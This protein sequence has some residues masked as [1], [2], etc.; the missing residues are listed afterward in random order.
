MEASRCADIHFESVWRQQAFVGMT[1]EQVTEYLSRDTLHMK[2]EL[3]V[4][5]A[6]LA[7]LNYNMDARK[8]QTKRIKSELSVVESGTSWFNRDT[9]ARNEQTKRIVSCFRM[10]YVHPTDL[11]RILQQHPVLSKHISADEVLEAVCTFTAGPCLKKR[12]LEN[13]TDRGTSIIYY[14]DTQGIVIEAIYDATKVKYR[15]LPQLNQSRIYYGLTMWRSFLY[16][17]GGK[18]CRKDQ[19]DEFLQ[20][21]ERFDPYTKKWEVLSQEMVEKRYYAAAISFEGMEL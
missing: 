16:A 9:D 15:N 12:R 17:V 5:E 7:W 11:R 8:E 10:E 3:S 1:I 19:P 21:V 18:I 14:R 6:G 4:V 20:S 2:S 13:K